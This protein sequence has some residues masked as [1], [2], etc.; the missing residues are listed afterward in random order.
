[1]PKFW[2]GSPNLYESSCTHLLW[3]W[4]YEKWLTDTTTTTDMHWSVRK[5]K[6]SSV[7]S[8]KIISLHTQNITVLYHDINLPSCRCDYLFCFRF[9]TPTCSTFYDTVC[10]FNHL[11]ETSLIC[12]SV[13]R[14]AFNRSYTE[15]ETGPD[16][17]QTVEKQLISRS[18]L[19]IYY[20]MPTY[21]TT[22][23]YTNI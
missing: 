9:V 8:M 11:F 23:Y 12:I 20:A 19:P 17:S 22:L 1:M 15:M 14:R 21:S 13:F 3:F 7:P 18:Y 2:G 6:Y 10:C 4:L 5:P 16:G